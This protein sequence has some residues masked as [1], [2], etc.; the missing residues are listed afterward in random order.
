[1][2][3]EK[4]PATVNLAD[5]IKAQE[6]MLA[7]VRVIERAQRAQVSSLGFIV[8][9]LESRANLEQKHHDAEMG[10]LMA[11]LTPSA[12]NPRERRNSQDSRKFTVPGVGVSVEVT[13]ATHKRV[14][15][16]FADQGGKA[17]AAIAMLILIHLAIWFGFYKPAVE[18]AYGTRKPAAPAAEQR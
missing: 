7:S 9:G 14:R 17:A 18:A 5:L 11:I 15:E 3:D 12:K 1:M 13:A 6:S 10:L 16:W 4:P 8:S 2:S